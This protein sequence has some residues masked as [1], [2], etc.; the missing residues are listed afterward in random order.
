MV[1]KTCYQLCTVWSV[2]NDYWL[3]KSQDNDQKFNLPL[4][5]GNLVNI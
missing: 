2:E 4:V 3:R 1:S 5:N